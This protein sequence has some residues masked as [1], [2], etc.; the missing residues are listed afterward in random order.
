MSKNLDK[1]E[2]FVAEIEAGVDPN[3]PLLVTQLTRE[4]EAGNIEG[5]ALI[6]KGR[7]A[8]QALM[9]IEEALKELKGQP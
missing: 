6:I 7:L 1:V 8:R 2:K 5:V 3:S 4:D 9:L